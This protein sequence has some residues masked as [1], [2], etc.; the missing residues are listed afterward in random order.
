MPY[1]PTLGSFLNCAL[2]NISDRC[3]AAPSRRSS[4]WLCDPRPWSASSVV[5]GEQ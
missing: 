3:T 2:L 1:M 4:V 5:A